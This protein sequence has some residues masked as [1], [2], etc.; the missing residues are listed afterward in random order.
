MKHLMLLLSI[1]IGLF[2][3]FTSAYA[4]GGP[5][6]PPVANAE[7]K[8]QVNDLTTG[9]SLAGVVVTLEGT[10]QTTYTDLD[11]NFKLNGMLPGKYNLV[12]S[13]IS[14]SRNRV[15]NVVLS[16]SEIENLEVKLE[17]AK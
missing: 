8:G 5:N 9:E 3:G 1:S 14:Y 16:E 11:G 12:F 15:E 2:S 7:I 17:E 10:D 4:S 13:Y 6:T